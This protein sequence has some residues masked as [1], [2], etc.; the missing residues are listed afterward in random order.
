[1]KKQWLGLLLCLIGCFFV[2]QSAVAGTLSWVSQDRWVTVK[3]IVDG[4]TFVTRKG[5]KIRLLGINTPETRHRSS[6]AEPFGKEAKQALQNLIA[7]KQVRLSFDRE[8]QD[9]YQR[10]LAH[11]YLRDGLWVNAE[12]LRLGL[13]H[14][15]TFTPNISAAKKLL[16]AEDEARAS[17][18]GM[19]THKRWKVLTVKQLK[20]P[21]LGQ[22]RLVQGKVSKL[23]KKGWKFWLGKLAV[24]V[25]RKYRK[26]FKGK[27]KVVVGDDVVVRGRLRMSRKGK[28]FLSVHTPSDVA[29]KP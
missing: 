13:A 24:S 5:E 14:V 25:P 29:H 12:L 19:W 15:Y 17:K 27:V 11:V 18:Q 20:T 7:G 8:K 9:R 2:G 3:R 6:P 23:D 26:G 16:L 1:M 21:I 10:T 22:F 4:D 28:W